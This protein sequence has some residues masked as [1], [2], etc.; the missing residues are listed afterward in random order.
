MQ[1]FSFKNFRVIFFFKIFVVVFVLFFL[2][3]MQKW[4]WNILR[5]THQG[6]LPHE[7]FKVLCSNLV[8]ETEFSPNVFWFPHKPKILYS[9]S[10]GPVPK[11]R[12]EGRK[13]YQNA[14]K[15]I[16][17]N[18]AFVLYCA[19]CHRHC[20]S[21]LFFSLWIPSCPYTC[22]EG[23]T[24]IAQWC[25]ESRMRAEPLNI[26]LAWWLWG[27]CGKGSLCWGCSWFYFSRKSQESPTFVSKWKGRVSNCEEWL[28]TGMWHLIHPD[29]GV[30]QFTT[31]W[32]ALHE[33]KSSPEYLD[34]LCSEHEG[35]LGFGGT[36]IVVQDEDFTVLQCPAVIFLKK[37]LRELKC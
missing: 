34:I 31:K 37:A 6:H 17:M 8:L 7:N 20:F 14:N 30:P 21:L 10:L 22:S 12:F 13:K 25:S 4:M 2:L 11:Q 5:D 23:I 15:A 27:C 26:F 9:D 3:E 1:C 19:L 18:H 35:K 16:S 28:E 32:C 29:C 24:P 33:P 36:S